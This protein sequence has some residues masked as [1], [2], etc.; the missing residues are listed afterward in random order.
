MGANP[1]SHGHP[2]ESFPMW[3]TLVVKAKA[4]WELY[5]LAADPVEL[6]D[7]AAAMPEKVKE[8][9]A[10]WQGW[11]ERCNGLSRP[12]DRKKE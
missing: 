3:R 9:A 4:E 5:D 11:A 12:G 7:L 1:W 8:L 2:R 10:R 6:K